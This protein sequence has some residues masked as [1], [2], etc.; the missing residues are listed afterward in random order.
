MI[1]RSAYRQLSA[2]VR[3]WQDE[4]ERAAR[5]I[6]IDVVRV[7][8]DS[9]QADVALGEFVAERRLRKTYN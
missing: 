6:E 4:V 9:A 3:E 1:G 8:L 5:D 2:R 7:G